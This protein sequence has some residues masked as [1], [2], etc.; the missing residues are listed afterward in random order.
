[1]IVYRGASAWNCLSPG[2]SGFVLATQGAGANPLWV[3]NSNPSA[4]QAANTIYSGP[5]SGPPAPPTFRAGTPADVQLGNVTN[6]AQA[7]ASIWPNVAATNNY[8][9]VGDGAKWNPATF[10]SVLSTYGTTGTGSIVLASSPALTGT[11][12]APTPA[13]T[14]NSTT[15]ATTAMVQS[16]VASIGCAGTAPV[17]VS[18]PQ[19][20]VPIDQ[21]DLLNGRFWYN[22]STYATFAAYLT[23]N[24]GAFARTP[25]GT[26][27][28]SDGYQKTAATNVA[29]FSYNPRNGQPKGLLLEPA[30]T[31]YALQSE[32][33]TNAV[34]TANNVTVTDNALKSPT[35]A[36][37][38]ATLQESGAGSVAHYV[39]QASIPPRSSGIINCSV[40]ARK[41][42]GKFINLSISTGTAN[43]YVQSVYDLSQ[44][45]LT[46]ITIGSYTTT[47]GI[48]TQMQWI[49]PAPD[50]ADGWYR[51]A[52]SVNFSSHPVTV[53]LN[54]GLASAAHGNTY[55]TNGNAVY[56][57]AGNTIGVYGAQCTQDS[58]GQLYS[59][60][61]T[62][63]V[64]VA[65]GG[66]IYY[67]GATWDNA[68][69]SLSAA[70]QYQ[71][72]SWVVNP[73]KAAI[74]TGYYGASSKTF[75]ASIADSTWQPTLE[76]TPGGTTTNF[77]NAQV[78]AINAISFRQ[79]PTTITASSNGAPVQTTAAGTARTAIT[80]VA[81]GSNP[82]VASQVIYGYIRNYALWN[83][84]L[85]NT[86]LPTTSSV[87]G[88]P[89]PVQVSTVVN[90]ALHFATWPSFAILPS[91][92]LFV[93][94]DKHPVSTPNSRPT[95]I[96]YA[97]SAGPNGPWNV[98]TGTCIPANTIDQGIWTFVNMDDGK[99]LGVGSPNFTPVPLMQSVLAT[100]NPDHS[101]TCT[102]PTT[103]TGS[104][105]FPLSGDFAAG[106]NIPIKL[107][108]GTWMLLFYGWS[109]PYTFKNSTLA[110]VFTTTPENPASWGNFIKLADPSTYAAT[111]YYADFNEASAFIDIAGNVQIIIRDDGNFTLD[112]TLTSHSY[113]R[114]TLP[115]GLDPTVLS[116]WSPPIWL[117]YSGDAAAPDVVNLG[118]HGVWMMSR[119][120]Q[121]ASTS[122]WYTQWADAQPPFPSHPAYY[123][124]SSYDTY[125]YSSSRL[126]NPTTV[127][128]A[129]DLGHS[130]TTSAILFLSS[131]FSGIGVSPW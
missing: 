66:D 95:T 103:I 91:G 21:A 129:T 2:S 55:D 62:T 33:F 108:N 98:A 116:N 16:L 121:V 50:F 18:C 110:A 89:V 64:P 78:P 81:F 73:L 37:T 85:A 52:T 51:I 71:T 101:V 65:G 12:T 100:E 31:N 57:S 93:A 20:I 79:D 59:Y 24:G 46:E 97:V 76:H 74:A 82:A 17:W 26:Y 84:G 109:S 127:G 80:K 40:Y 1:M 68:A 25:S 107:P 128:T 42:T 4:A 72:K 28:G 36:T 30:F 90:D 88:L 120:N 56:V 41:S 45:G 106:R 118:N 63:T 48:S 38:A 87:S 44:G 34:W 58:Q 35:S 92:Y 102:A 47:S 124:N 49:E 6:D 86:S 119:Y 22:G 75:L 5:T 113:W 114:Q 43:E 11:P 39:S 105:F 99:L 123:L 29:R 54:I 14:D 77:L 112:G 27:T 117:G 7:K 125:Y 111:A 15:V 67:I 104:P 53:S 19:G 60:Q 13:T 126:L 131:P 32:A 69:N 70:V 83:T 122:A 96:D 61:P 10:A 130:S 94:W 3:A 9:A 23:A 8:L 115:A